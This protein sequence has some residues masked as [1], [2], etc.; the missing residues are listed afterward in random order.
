MTNK[1]VVGLNEGAFDHVSPAP[2]LWSYPV[3]ITCV[4]VCVY[5]CVCASVYVSVHVN[6]YVVE[7]GGVLGAHPY[8]SCCTHVPTPPSVLPHLSPSLPH[9]TSTVSDSNHSFPQL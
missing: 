6:V 8:S 4:Y 5:V 1:I 2:Q 3:T 7:C 9:V